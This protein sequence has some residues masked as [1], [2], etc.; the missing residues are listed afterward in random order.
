MIPANGC[1]SYCLMARLVTLFLRQSRLSMP[2]LDLRGLRC[3][4]CLQPFCPA[5]P[6]GVVVSEARIRN[7]DGLQWL[8]LQTSRNSRRDQAAW[9]S[10]CVLQFLLVYV[11][12]IGESRVSS[13]APE[14]PR[15]F[16]SSGRR[17]RLSLP[18]QVVRSTVLQ[19]KNLYI[20][21]RL[22]IC[23][24]IS[25]TS[26]LRQQ[27]YGRSVPQTEKASELKSLGMEYS[28]PR[29]P[30]FGRDGRELGTLKCSGCRRM[31][32]RLVPQ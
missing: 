31:R 24:Q 1:S 29:G 26:N 14:I 5:S 6:V 10:S 8:V 13:F 22:P 15:T 3:P 11:C 12:A 2:I 23:A 32:A 28:S 16:C 19:K 9:L 7:L 20:T 27:G 17:G 30:S 21:A 25:L 18:D 4:S